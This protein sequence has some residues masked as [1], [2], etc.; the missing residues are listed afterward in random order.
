M[1]SDRHMEAQHEMPEQLARWRSIAETQKEKVEEQRPA[2]RA[3]EDVMTTIVRA[4]EDGVEEV[5][6]TRLKRIAYAHHFIHKSPDVR[7]DEAK[8]G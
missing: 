3:W 5:S 7:E 4:D 6:L 8:R 1:G 2:V